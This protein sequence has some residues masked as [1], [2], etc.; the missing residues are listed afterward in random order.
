MMRPPK[1]TVV[2]IKLPMRTDLQR[3]G[4]YVRVIFNW[5]LVNSNNSDA[6]QSSR[7]G[8]RHCGTKC[9]GN[10]AS[11]KTRV[12]VKSSDTVPRHRSLTRNRSKVERRT[13][14]EP[15]QQKFLSLRPPKADA[16]DAFHTERRCEAKPPL[17]GMNQ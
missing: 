10:F 6:L 5:R 7:E 13:A 11:C 15:P 1:N 14:V 4:A 9:I 2:K 17:D 12:T 8:I 16:I 3:C